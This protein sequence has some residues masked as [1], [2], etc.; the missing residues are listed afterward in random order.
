MLLLFLFL[1][2][3]ES[4]PYIPEHRLDNTYLGCNSS[5]IKLE[6]GTNGSFSQEK[7]LNTA[8][9]GPFGPNIKLLVG[10]STC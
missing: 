4:Y 6:S 8:I 10:I 3:K 9:L 7:G 1:T 5:K 2:R